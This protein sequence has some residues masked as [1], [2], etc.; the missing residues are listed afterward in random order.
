[1]TN[2][3]PVQVT[4]WTNYP[5]TLT[6]WA[7]TITVTTPTGTL[8]T[9][10]NGAT[11]VQGTASNDQVILAVQLAGDWLVSAQFDDQT[12]SETVNVQAE[13]NYPIRLWVPTI[14]PTV[15]TGSV[16]TCT[17]GE[18]VLTKTSQSGKVKFYVPTLGEWTLNA[19]L[20]QQS[21]NTV[22]VDVQEDRDYPLLLS[23]TFATITVSTVAGTEIT[24]QNG[25]IIITQTADSNGE[26][27]FEVAT[28]GTWTV[29]ADFDGELVSAGVSVNEAINYDVSLMPT[30]PGEIYGAYW[31]GTASPAWTRTDAAS[32]FPDPNPAVNNGTGSS[33][34][35]EIMPWAGMVKVED[36]VAGTLVAI[37]KYW[38]KWTR[39]GVSMKLQIANYAAP[40]F[41]V[42]PAHADREDGQGE[43]D[44]VYVGRYHC[45]SDYKSTTG[46][47]PLNNITRAMSRQNISALGAEY[48]QYDFAMY[49][50]IA[51][52][53]LVEFTNWNSQ[54]MIGYG[55]SPSGALFNMGLTDTMQYHTGTSALT[56]DTYGCCQY[57]N[58]E[59]LWDNVY[60]WCDGIYF[61][62]SS[63]YCIKTPENFSDTNGGQ[64]I[65]PQVNLRGYI[66]EWSNPSID[67]FQYALYPIKTGGSATTYMCD[68]VVSSLGGRDLY[69]GGGATQSQTLGE[70]QWYTISLPDYLKG[71]RSQK[72]PNS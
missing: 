60:D 40:G 39:D 72:L 4:D 62:N 10:Q 47:L 20:N 33:P 58:I 61:S 57:R 67:E 55:C 14:V 19:T 34:F 16:V 3:V 22:I 30:P 29:S 1:M 71:C 28:F 44:I 69:V 46:V 12:D 35:D 70:F 66:T 37:P 31:A 26:A 43:R 24:A 59:G 53:Y 21:S 51:M 5:V 64:N 13:E 25:N 65:G 54:E 7:A 8:V 68:N 9:A 17:Q 45:A 42:S 49:W 6:I 56:R 36:D 23:Y 52:L 18:T 48:W 50:T 41:Y 2:A 27:V 32:N 38:Y 15:V 63:V 11:Q